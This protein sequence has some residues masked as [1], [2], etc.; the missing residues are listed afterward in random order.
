[1]SARLQ[2]NKLTYKR[3]KFLYTNFCWILLYGFDSANSSF[4]LALRS[5][6]TRIDDSGN[7]S[8]AHSSLSKV[9]RY[10]RRNLSNIGCMRI[11]CCYKNTWMAAW[12]RHFP[13]L[14]TCILSVSGQN[15]LGQKRTR[16]SS[17][18]IIISLFLYSRIFS[19]IYIL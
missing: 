6:P 13:N 15:F 9:D 16:R 3:L 8:L 10:L 1:M 12:T 11:K 5:Y 4:K 19:A 17:I 14:L 2:S 18:V 7:I